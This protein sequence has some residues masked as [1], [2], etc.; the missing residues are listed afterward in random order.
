MGQQPRT[1][2]SRLCASLCASHE[3]DTPAEWCNF[4]GLLV[5]GDIHGNWAALVSVLTVMEKILSAP[6]ERSCVVFLKDIVDRGLKS[7]ECF[8]LVMLY[9][10]VSSSR[11]FLRLCDHEFHTSVEYPQPR[12]SPRTFYPT[13]TSYAYS[14]TQYSYPVTHEHPIFKQLIL[15]W[16]HISIIAVSNLHY[17]HLPPLPLRSMYSAVQRLSDST[18]TRGG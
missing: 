10:L 13:E 5:V 16:M 14:Y 7:F 17:Q 11:V 15:L 1:H 2:H 18:H 4:H 6:A 3:G 8:V 9:N 12:K